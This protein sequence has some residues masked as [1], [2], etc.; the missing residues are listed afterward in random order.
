MS[1]RASEGGVRGAELPGGGRGEKR[2]RREEGE[3]EERGGGRAGRGGRRKEGTHTV[4]QLVYNGNLQSGR[5]Y[6]N[7]AQHPT[8]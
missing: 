8:H 1:G 4:D 7:T 6:F 2:E 3:E 5:L